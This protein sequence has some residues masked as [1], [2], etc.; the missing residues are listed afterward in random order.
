MPNGQQ[1]SPRSP[2]SQNAPARHSCAERLLIFGLGSA[3]LATIAACSAADDNVGTTE[4]AATK[5]PD[6]PCTS[7]KP[8]PKPPCKVTH[9]FS[10]NPTTI[11]QGQGSTLT[12]SASV[13]SGCSQ[14]T[15][16]I[17]GQAVSQ[18]G[19]MTVW[20]STS[21]TYSMY[22]TG[23]SI[24]VRSVTVSVVP[25]LCSN[26]CWS[27]A[28][29]GST[30]SNAD[31]SLGTCGQAGNCEACSAGVC[32][33]VYACDKQCMAN[34]WVTSCNAWSF[35]A[36]GDADL[37]GIP[38]L[39]ESELARRFFP[40]LRLRYTPFNGSGPNGDWG[41]LY[42]GGALVAAGPPTPG[43]WQYVVR[44][45]SPYRDTTEIVT[46]N[47]QVFRSGSLQQCSGNEC[48]EIIFSI[49]Y[50]WDLGATSLE[51]HPH[52]GDVE[53]YAVLVTRRDPLRSV[54]AESTAP[55]WNTSWELAK[56]DPNAWV[57]YSE[58]GTAHTCAEYDSSNWRYR[59]FRPAIDGV[60]TVWVAQG[61]HG[62]YFSQEACNNG[63][64]SGDI[65]SRPCWD[66]CNNNDFE[67][68]FA[69]RYGSGSG[70]L[71][72]AGE[73]ACHSHWTIDHY[74]SY[75]GS[76]RTYYSYGSYDVWSDVPFG[77]D[78]VGRHSV[79]LRPGTM[80]WWADTHPYTC[81][82]GPSSSPPPP[83]EPP[84]PTITPPPPIDSP[85]PGTQPRCC[86]DIDDQGHCTLCVPEGASC[87]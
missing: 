81:W 28:A 27:G 85:C 34:G 33:S 37:D 63:A 40:T 52:R 70:P 1:T 5:C 20:P 23:A 22:L 9:S 48:L 35:D 73:E 2:S 60:T 53:M 57:G 79:L 36:A 26:V 69:Q 58:F 11:A 30:C 31:L 12:W 51:I 67:L 68:V 16:S 19:S 44:P 82:P 83:P 38:D 3:V 75:P 87:P 7:P 80:L 47:G 65:L 76:Q 64:C 13:P 78:G 86:G 42:S 55:R 54:A 84:Q 77:N 56:N 46:V 59:I 29:C 25:A 66:R 43:D 6:P 72:N 8:P 62:N 39:L 4:Q 14:P 18:S 10:A 71:R 17:S 41:Q 74:T 61:K 45:V 24:P 49:P 32:N 50:N 15:V 21:T